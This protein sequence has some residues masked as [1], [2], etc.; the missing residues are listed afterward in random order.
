MH[1]TTFSS[2]Q[3]IGRADTVD[4]MCRE[5]WL[6]QGW[7]LQ[8]W[9]GGWRTEAARRNGKNWVCSAWRRE[10]LQGDLTAAYKSLMGGWRED[11]VR[12]FLEVRSNGMERQQAQTGTW[13]TPIRYKETFLPRGTDCPQR[14]WTPQASRPSGPDCAWP[15][16]TW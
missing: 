8:S 1:S 5:G 3:V 12:L 13:Q 14:L 4:K 11:V 10:S 16:E 6:S 9:L 15:G 7:L 2:D